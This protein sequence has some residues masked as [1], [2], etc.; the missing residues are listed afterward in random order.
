MCSLTGKSS[1]VCCIKQCADKTLP[2]KAECKGTFLFTS[3]LLFLFNDIYLIYKHWLDRHEHRWVHLWCTSEGAIVPAQ[4]LSGRSHHSLIF[5]TLNLGICWGGGEVMRVSCSQT[6]DIYFTHGLSFLQNQSLKNIYIS[7]W[8]PNVY[9]MLVRSDN[10]SLV[11]TCVLS[12]QGKC[13]IF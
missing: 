13:L 3:L 2:V 8:R 9:T 12:S 6:K 7:L 1:L 4:G 5:H 10:I 11:M